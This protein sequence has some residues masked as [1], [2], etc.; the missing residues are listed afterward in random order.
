MAASE[1]TET[2]AAASAASTIWA[3]VPHASVPHASVPHA[4]ADANAPNLGPNRG[5]SRLLGM[6]SDRQPAKDPA[7]DVPQHHH[8]V[9]ECARRPNQFASTVTSRGDG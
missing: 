8:H 9:A 4:R 6:G 2:A 7:W 5:P 3:S 1:T